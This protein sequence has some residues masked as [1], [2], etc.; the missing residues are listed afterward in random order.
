MLVKTVLR[1]TVQSSVFLSHVSFAQVDSNF[2]DF[3]HCGF[4]SQNRADSTL[5]T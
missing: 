2:T 4:M 3:L 1:V 5:S